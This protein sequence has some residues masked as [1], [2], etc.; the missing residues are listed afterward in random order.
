MDIVKSI[1]IGMFATIFCP[2]LTMLAWINTNHDPK[3]RIQIANID[4]ISDNVK[5]F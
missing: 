2:I 3:I 5:L 1:N 4:N